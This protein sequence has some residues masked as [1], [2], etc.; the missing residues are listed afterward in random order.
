MARMA[1][2]DEDLV[3]R[4]LAGSGRAWRQLLGRYERRLYNHAV[5]LTGH[6]DDAVDLTQEILMAVFRNLHTFRGD[7]PFSAW[8]FRIAAYRCTDHLR[9]RRVHDPFDETTGEW[10]GDG[11]TEP[12]AA[13][14]TLR[15]NDRL[16][17][18]LGRLPD[19]QRLVVELKFFQQFTFE[20]IAAQ[21]GIS[22]N[23][24]KTRLYA[25]LRKLRGDRDIEALES[26]S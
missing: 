24:A 1:P 25:A 12:E 17:A 23:T 6:R 5:R 8:L 13:A 14:G 10:A 15:A 11:R 21:L 20:D 7:C 2:A 4:A 19:E 9:R 16:R 22:P 26:A 3:E 18:A